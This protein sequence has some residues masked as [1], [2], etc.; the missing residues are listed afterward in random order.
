[1]NI[2]SNASAFCLALLLA[3]T[4]ATA[5]PVAE[6]TSA[7]PAPDEQ[8]VSDVLPVAD[9]FVAAGFDLVQPGNPVLGGSK[10]CALAKTDLG[11]AP[12]WLRTY[13]VSLMS[14][15]SGVAPAADGGFVLVGTAF[16]W[17]NYSG[18]KIVIIR[19]DAAGNQL[20]TKL[21]DG[22]GAEGVDTTQGRDIQATADGGFVVLGVREPIDLPASP[23][24]LLKVDAD[25]NELW[26]S[27]PGDPYAE[28][29]QVSPTAD[30]GFVVAG[31]R[32][33]GTGSP[34]S[35]APADYR[36]WLLRVDA[37]GQRVWAADY[38]MPT[39]A[40]A[41]G[42]AAQ[43]TPDGGFA[44][45]GYTGLYGETDTLDAL[46]LKVDAAG[47]RQW[48]VTFGGAGDDIASDLS[49]APDGGI[50]VTGSQPTPYA[51]VFQEEQLFVTKFNASGEQR[52]ELLLNGAPAGEEGWAFGTAIEPTADGGAIVAGGVHANNPGSATTGD[53]DV[54]FVKLGP[55]PVLPPVAVGIDVRPG[56]D[57][58]PIN[59]A[60][61]GT[62]PVA[63]LTTPAFDAASVDRTTV[64]FAG[65]PVA[66]KS[67]GK[68]Q[69]SLEDVDGDGDK[70]LI[71]HF[72]LP[73]LQLEAGAAAATLSGATFDGAE[74]S[75]A[76]G[77]TVQ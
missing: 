27:F 32:F 40:M 12:L 52:W 19:T 24:M 26:R 42:L 55:E 47:G 17:S 48:D 69:G 60:A 5:A 16:R 14:A 61:M 10:A 50:L 64:R 49:I 70:D 43:E 63:V 11:G 33:A 28:A 30:G 29:Y 2:G 39:G 21:H 41:F 53:V 37:A 71:L 73:D 65:A 20:W 7:I 25:G 18:G 57:E 45:A 35:P 54:W 68:L 76:D 59:L 46:L 51:A 22:N 77:V 56:S 75:G 62:V 8:R 44:L 58:N 36:A 31:W 13:P 72:N 15:C 34:L 4:A 23:I 74:I 3:A 38:A 1:M 67:N 9:G 6:W 66:T